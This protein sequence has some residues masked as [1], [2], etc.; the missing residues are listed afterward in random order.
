MIRIFGITDTAFSTNGDKVIQPLKAKVRKEDNGQFF[1]ELETDLSCVDWITE[2]RIAVVP[3]PQGNQAF[4]IDNVQ[5]TKHKLST[6]ARHVYFDSENY[7]I[8]D[9][10]VVEKDCNDALDHLNL[11]TEPASP[12]TTISDIGTV[13][14]F[15][16][17]RR[18]LREAFEEVLARWGGHLVRDNFNVAIRASI[19]QDNGVV[20][21]Y[22]KNLK[23][24][25]CAEN[26]NDVVTKILPT[27]K[28]GLML[29]EVYLTASTQYA[30]PYTKT[31]VFNQDRVNEEDYQ[32]ASGNTDEDAYN[33]ALIADLRQQAQ[34]YLDANSIP[35]VSY[36]LR[37]NLEKITDIGDTVRVQ[38]ER[39][40][41]DI[42]THVIAY[43]YDAIAGRYTEL[44]FGNFEEKLTGLMSRISV[45]AEEI[46]KTEAETVRVTLSNE[47]TAATGQI[48]STLGNSYVIY[49][50]D[51]ILVV[52]TLP[53][54]NATNVI[55][56]NNGG[57]AFSNTGINGT[58][59]SAW[60]ID[61]TLNMQAINVINLTASM[62]KGG[63]LKLGS[64][65]NA[66]GILELYD[67]ANNLIGLMNKD[68]L[69]MFG[70]DGSYVLMNNTV[71]FAGFDRNG[72]KLY[73]ADKDEF[74]MKKCVSEEEITLCNQLRF[75]SIQIKNG[76]T[77]VNE[78]IG[79]VSAM[80]GGVS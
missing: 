8:A 50:G 44:E 73:W 60:T 79:L 28:D 51:K 9:S 35:K 34:S 55:L 21:R 22:R 61:G 53:K 18:S 52:D 43:E 45:N 19:G 76:N 26:W 68:G 58:F 62:I 12:Y 10:Y 25:T 41:I 70:A 66:S 2:G 42:L 29:P 56:I 74:H 36:T 1:C 14:S 3:T 16:C 40:G 69:K 54:E 5:K 7:L 17:V 46:A 63:T 23:E 27:G 78:G 13:G 57:I 77:I 31:V 20:V 11:A 38:D 48:W 65:L 47:L 59:N 49:E 37:A 15:R 64:N 80:S 67:D 30:I 32:D 39:L 72:V 71:G 4:R 6:T 24:I 33:A 75:I